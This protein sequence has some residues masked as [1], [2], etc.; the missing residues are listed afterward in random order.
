MPNYWLKN[1]VNKIQKVYLTRSDDTFV[2][3]S[4]RPALADQVHA[5]AFISFHFDSSPVKTQLRD[6]RLIIITKTP[7]S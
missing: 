7:P 2:S 1:Y 4:K 3:L 6:L 5:D